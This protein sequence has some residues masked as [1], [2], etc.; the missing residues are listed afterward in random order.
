MTGTAMKNEDKTPL[1]KKER[2]N[3]N[4]L[5]VCLVLGGV[6]GAAMAL[7]EGPKN[8]MDGFL[9]SNAPLPKT[10]ALIFAFIWA[11]IVPGIAWYW[12]R[13]AVDEQEAH[14][15]REGAYYAFYGYAIGAPL[16]W[17]LWRGGLVPAPNGIVIYYITLSICGVVWLWKKYR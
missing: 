10:A 16:W 9:F 6:M 2:L 8:A 3:R 12:H 5:I 13:Y 14:A 7:I 17:M 4:L 1:S 11:V 15:Y